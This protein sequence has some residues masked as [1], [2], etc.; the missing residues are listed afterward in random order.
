VSR[1]MEFRARIG[2]ERFADVAFADL[3]ED[4]LSALRAAYARIGIGFSD[5]SRD[6]V[7]RWARGHEPGAHGQHAY[8]LAD[9]G[10]RAE[11]V[12]ERFAP[13][14]QAFDAVA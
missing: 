11:Q 13:Y 8:D 7:A 10:L 12:R 5:A 1:A 9:F 2:D 6:A 3:Q 4:P 14:L